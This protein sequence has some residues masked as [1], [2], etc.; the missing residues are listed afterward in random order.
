ML[1]YNGIYNFQE[2]KCRHNW[3]IKNKN[4]KREKGETTQKNLMLF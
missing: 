4:L 1:K 2:V 3:M